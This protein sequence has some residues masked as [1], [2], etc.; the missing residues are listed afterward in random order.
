MDVWRPWLFFIVF[1]NID[2]IGEYLIFLCSFW[3]KSM[4]LNARNANLTRSKICIEVI[5]FLNMSIQNQATV[6]W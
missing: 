1:T 4:G 6:G 2:N 3:C 5:S